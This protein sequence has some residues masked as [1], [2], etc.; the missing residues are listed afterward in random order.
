MT[1]YNCQKCRNKGMIMVA[2]NGFTRLRECSCMNARRSLQTLERSGL[3]E[4]VR[5]CRFDTY[6]TPEIWQQTAMQAAQAFA[7]EPGGRWFLAS[8]Q[9]GSGKTHLCAAICRELMLPPRCMSTRYM[10]WMEEAKLL[11]ACVND[12]EEYQRRIHPLKT[13]DVLYIDDFLKCKA[14]ERPTP[15]DI[16]LAFE[17]IN[18]RYLKSK[19]VTVISTEWFSDD[20]LEIDGALGSRIY[21]K[22]RNTTISIIGEEKNW[23]LR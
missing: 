14:G 7:M 2:E 1:G 21:E 10:L 6:Q 12:A 13:V 19:L 3:S 9:P 4:L 16:N 23:R 11:K 5:R 20:L 22:A 8:G 15:G 18:A 17:I